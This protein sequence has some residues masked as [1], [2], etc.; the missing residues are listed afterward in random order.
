MKQKQQK[1]ARKRRGRPP[2]FP[3]LRAEVVQALRTLRAPHMR[4]PRGVGARGPD[5]DVVSYKEIASFLGR[6]IANHTM[7][8][9]CRGLLRTRKNA[10]KEPNRPQT[11]TQMLG[12]RLSQ[13]SQGW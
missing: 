3:S 7:E 13:N 5:K 6:K 10:H 11:Q 8:V 2:I 1:N 12:L 9:A 4:P